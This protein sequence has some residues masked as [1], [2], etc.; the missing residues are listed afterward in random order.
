VAKAKASDE[1]EAPE[2]APAST[3][4]REVP[5]FAEKYPRDDAL[6]ALVDAFTRGDY[7]TVRRDAPRLAG[8]SKDPDVQRAARE[9]RRRIDPDPVSLV[10]VL[11]AMVLLGVLSFHYLGH[12]HAAA[13]PQ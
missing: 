12:P 9:L 11:V 1:S 2:K 10:L 8:E 7:R 3:P 4:A 5:A 13:V 6:D